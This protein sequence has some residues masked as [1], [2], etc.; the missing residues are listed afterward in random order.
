[1]EKINIGTS[2]EIG[3]SVT[4]NES[5]LHIGSGTLEV[6]STPSMIAI[7]EKAS[8]MCIEQYLGNQ[9]TSVGAA[10]NVKHLRPTAIGKYIT[11]RSKI[12]SVDRK[13]IEF[14]VEV[15]ENDKL[16]GKGTHTRVIITKDTFMDSL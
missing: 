12:T 9:E 4:A 16:I 14:E 13:K 5:A 10:V 8:L 15:H 2:Y 7:M 6:Y 11:C 3:K 1:M